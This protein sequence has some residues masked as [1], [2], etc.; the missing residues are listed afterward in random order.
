[1]VGGLTL[2]HLNVS[3]KVNLS[4]TGDVNAT[5]FYGDEFYDSGVLLFNFV[6]S[7]LVVANIGNASRTESSIVNNMTKVRAEIGTN[8]TSLRLNDTA[9]LSNISS[10]N[11]SLGQKADRSEVISGSV[12]DDIIAGI[13]A[14]VSLLEANDTAQF[15]NISNMNTTLGKKLDRG[16]VTNFNDADIIAGL[17]SNITRTEGHID[18][19][20]TKVR[21]E[22]ES[23]ASR[24]FLNG[25][26]LGSSQINVSIL[27]VTGE[28]N[29]NGTMNLNSNKIRNIL[30]L[31]APDGSIIAFGDNPVFSDFSGLD[32]Y[33]HH[34]HLQNEVSPAP[35]P[36]II[37]VIEEARVLAASAKD[38]G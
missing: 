16:E 36:S 18:N 26:A 12:T 21:S 8:V 1:M 6:D 25:T 35:E 27:N 24:L 4:S 14:N 37:E 23:N 11:T 31:S 30:S 9:L 32:N 5:T 28:S 38:A 34:K 17:A 10:L 2:P 7:D 29:F 3:A 15:T 33:P 19:N 20:V 13:I 22:I